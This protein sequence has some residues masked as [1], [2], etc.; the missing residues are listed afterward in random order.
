MDDAF[1]V[2]ARQERM[3]QEIYTGHTE[4]YSLWGRMESDYTL[5]KS[6][7]KFADVGDAVR[8]ALYT[9]RHVEARREI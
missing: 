2:M 7:V 3:R 5:I 9:W 6:G 8:N 1:D 4:T